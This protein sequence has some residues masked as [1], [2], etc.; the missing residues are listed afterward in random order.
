MTVLI[1]PC[2][3]LNIDPQALADLLALGGV[4]A[5]LTPPLCTPEGLTYLRRF[6]ADEPSPR[7][8]GAC[9]PEVN[10]GLFR[11]LA[12]EAGLG[13]VDLLSVGDLETAA[14]A[15]TLALAAPPLPEE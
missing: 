14:S 7:L 15:L 12:G 8:L 10:A 1:C 6:L 11:R 2:P 3:D 4:E 9:S 5:R 13:V